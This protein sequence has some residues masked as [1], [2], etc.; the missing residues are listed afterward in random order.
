MILTKKYYFMIFQYVR[1]QSKFIISFGPPII[2]RNKLRSLSCFDY[3][4]YNICIRSK[5]SRFR[6]CGNQR[7]QAEETLIIDNPLVKTHLQFKQLKWIRFS[8]KFATSLGPIDFQLSPL[9]NQAT[10]F[11]LLLCQGPLKLKYYLTYVWIRRTEHF[12]TNQ[13]SY[14]QKY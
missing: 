13:A 9:I 8:Q 11:N 12:T 7:N 3:E 6:R 14:T 1:K 10:S 2:I 4:E 5:H